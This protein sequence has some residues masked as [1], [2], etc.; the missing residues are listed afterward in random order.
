MH[1]IC[2][3]HP[4]TI[5]P[6]PWSM[7]KIIFHKTGQWCQKFGDRCLGNL[8]LKKKIKGMTSPHFKWS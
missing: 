6:S 7:E 8:T 5:P 3:N 4:A 1:V 2:L